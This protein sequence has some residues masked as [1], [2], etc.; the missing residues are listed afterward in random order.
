MEQDV[1]MAAAVITI[2]TLVAE[3]DTVYAHQLVQAIRQVQAS[4]R[5]IRGPLALSIAKGI[6]RKTI[7]PGETAG[8]RLVVVGNGNGRE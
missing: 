3:S 7:A 5:A 6:I 1:Y 2:G 8:P 4:K